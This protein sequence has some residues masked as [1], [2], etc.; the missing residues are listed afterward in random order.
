MLHNISEPNL[1]IFFKI[2]S[3]QLLL[4]TFLFSFVCI[5]LW[6]QGL[7]LARQVLCYWS[8]ISILF[9]LG[10]FL[11]M[12]FPS[13]ISN[14]DPPVTASQVAGITGAS[15]Q[16]DFVAIE[17]LF[18][19]LTYR[20]FARIVLKTRA[21]LLLLYLFS[22]APARFLCLSPCTRSLHM[23]LMRISGQSHSLLLSISV[24]LS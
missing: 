17:L 15:Y 20:K 19:T 23:H 4:K 24:H 12:L 3:W 8:L 6:T 7:V 10:V 9:I 22:F 2:V 21:S 13:L 18:L 1:R 14:C 5:G 11:I 16:M